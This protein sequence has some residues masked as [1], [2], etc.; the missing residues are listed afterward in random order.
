MFWFVFQNKCINEMKFDNCSDEDERERKEQVNSSY[1]KLFFSKT[2]LHIR[3]VLKVRLPKNLC[4]RTF[5]INPHTQIRR[6]LGGGSPVVFEEVRLK[7]FCSEK[8]TKQTLQTWSRAKRWKLHL[9]FRGRSV[10]NYDWH[11][12]KNIF[13]SKRNFLGGTWSPASS[14]TTAA[15]NAGKQYF[16]SQTS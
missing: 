10:I 11:Y 6:E 16:K 9:E 15:T 7:S 2:I 1:I 13:Y 4:L 5:W 12:N 8:S 3:G 14:R